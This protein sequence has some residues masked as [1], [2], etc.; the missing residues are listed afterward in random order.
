MTAKHSLYFFFSL[1]IASCV[2]A[3]VGAQEWIVATTGSYHFNTRHYYNE[4]NFGLGYETEFRKN[5]KGSFGFYRNS[6]RKDT[7]YTGIT[8]LPLN[9]GKFRIGGT[10]MLI[11]GYSE[12]QEFVPIAAPMIHYEQ[13]KW[14][15]NTIMTTSVVAFQVKWKLD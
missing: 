11:S 15:V 14:G 4:K 3:P 1:L 13:Q 7:L 8:Y 2:P 5:V 12:K 10:A 9:F 6:F